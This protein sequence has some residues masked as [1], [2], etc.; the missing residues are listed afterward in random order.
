MLASMVSTVVTWIPMALALAA[1]AVC[2]AAERRRPAAR[3]DMARA[4]LFAGGLLAVAFALSPWLDELADR[5]LSA[6]MFEHLVLTCVAAPLLAFGDPLVRFHRHVRTPVARGASRRL[7]RAVRSPAI[8]AAA[9]IAT[10]WFWHAPALYDAAR[11]HAPLHAL[12]HLSFLVTGIMLWYA[13]VARPLRTGRLLGTGLI[14][15]VVSSVTSG[16][17]GALLAF[18]SR[19]WYADYSRQ[20]SSL[21]TAVVDQQL[22]GIL[23]WLGTM[24]LLLAASLA[25][26]ARL[27]R[28]TERTPLLVPVGVGQEP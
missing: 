21:R 13:A 24:P 10:M 7:S 19:P 11:R 22:A 12:E 14:A 25:L 20:A 16:A 5:L 26:G 27:I 15:L 8:G 23:M 4:Y 3:R 1:A 17:L 18:S 28:D 2:V 9:A 6:H